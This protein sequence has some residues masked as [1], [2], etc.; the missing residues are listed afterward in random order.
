MPY[1]IHACVHRQ[2][3]CEETVNCGFWILVFIF[4]F[5]IRPWF[6]VNRFL[7]FLLQLAPSCG[8]LLVFVF[9]LPKSLFWSFRSLHIRASEHFTFRLQKS[10]YLA[11]R[12]I[13]WL[14]KYPHCSHEEGILLLVLCCMKFSEH[15]WAIF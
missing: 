4:L 12:F 13:F 1:Y 6:D 3:L 2:K 5:E 9:G 11:I 8:R 15:L 7:W 14:Q 10:S